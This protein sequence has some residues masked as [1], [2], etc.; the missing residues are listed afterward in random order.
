MRWLA[1]VV[2]VV[3]GCAHET[4][5]QKQYKEALNAWVG[6]DVNRAFE[7]MGPPTDSFRMPNGRTQYTWVVSGVAATTHLGRVSRD[8]TK[9]C[10]TVFTA[11]PEGV[12]DAI[13]SEGRC[14]VGK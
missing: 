14:G 10:K 3:S 8:R 13:R 9:R 6:Q 1:L 7:M 11:T 2:L 5:Q 4:T 12:V